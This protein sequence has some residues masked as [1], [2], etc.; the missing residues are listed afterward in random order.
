MLDDCLQLSITDLKRLGYIKPL[1]SVSGVLIWRSQFNKSEVSINSN[2]LTNVITLSYLSNGEPQKQTI[3]LTKVQSNLSKGFYYYFLCP[4][5]NKP[6]RKLHLYKGVFCHRTSFKGLYDNQQYSK[7]HRALNRFYRDEMLF[8]KY[9]DQINS[10]HFQ[11]YYK[12]LPTKRYQRIL[13]RTGIK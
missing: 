7:E 9:L 2:T 8:P 3:T 12:G 11:A 13:N 1:M 5:T 4:I 6:C 10:K